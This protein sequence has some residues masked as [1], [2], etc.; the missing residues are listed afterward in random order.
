MAVPMLPVRRCLSRDWRMAFQLDDAR[1]QHP[2]AAG[3]VA[4]QLPMLK[5]KRSFS[6]GFSAAMIAVASSVA[7]WCVVATIGFEDLDRLRHVV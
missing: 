5:H 6:R 1:H 2:S 3:F 7:A 4:D